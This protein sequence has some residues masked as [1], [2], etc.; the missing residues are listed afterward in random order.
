[1]AT[2]HKAAEAAFSRAHAR[3]D[4]RF[5]LVRDCGAGPSRLRAAWDAH[6]RAVSSAWQ[7]FL[8]ATGQ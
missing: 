3:A 8:R 7:K 2:M 1:M 5:K 6:Q 4:K